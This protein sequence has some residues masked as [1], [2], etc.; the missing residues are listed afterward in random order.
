MTKGFGT[1]GIPLQLILS[2]YVISQ[3]PQNHYSRR[4]SEPGL[5]RLVHL[6]SYH[7]SSFHLQVLLIEADRAIRI[8]I[9]S[10]ACARI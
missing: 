5:L 7:A 6:P 1:K 10:L 9:R 3:Q 8:V 2:F 4:S